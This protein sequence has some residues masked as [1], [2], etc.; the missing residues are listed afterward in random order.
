MDGK[1]SRPTS[2]EIKNDLDVSE[3]ALDIGGNQSRNLN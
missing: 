1:R 2:A 3:V